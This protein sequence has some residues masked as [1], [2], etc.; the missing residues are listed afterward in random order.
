MEKNAGDDGDVTEDKLQLDYV[1]VHLPLLVR[2]QLEPEQA[3]SYSD[4]RSDSMDVPYTFFWILACA[5]RGRVERE[6]DKA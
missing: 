3:A 6:R 4:T 1:H 5:D 2:M